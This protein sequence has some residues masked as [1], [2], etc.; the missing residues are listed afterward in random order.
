MAITAKLINYN[1]QSEADMQMNYC[2]G[3]YQQVVKDI[4]AQAADV[5]RALIVWKHTEIVDIVNAWNVP[6]TKWPDTLDYSFDIVFQLNFASD[7]DKNPTMAYNCY[8]YENNQMACDDAVKE[9][10]KDY[11]TFDVALPVAADVEKTTDEKEKKDKK[12]NKDKREKQLKNDAEGT[13]NLR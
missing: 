11:P 12:E 8:D 6:V 13:P 9:W 3:E 7:T 5:Q 1:L 4:T 10:L 2:S